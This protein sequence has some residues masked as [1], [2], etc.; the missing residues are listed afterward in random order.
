M[1]TLV[2]SCAVRALTLEPSAGRWLPSMVLTLVA[3]IAALLMPAS[4]AR[5]Q[6]FEE[7]AVVFNPLTKRSIDSAVLALNLDNDQ[8]D[9]AKDLYVGYRSAMKTAMREMESK[10]K[11][12]M[13]KARESGDWDAIRKGQMALAKEMFENVGKLEDRFNEDLKAMLS[14]EQAAKFPS[15]ERARRRENARL[16]QLMAGEAA[17]AIDILRAL[18]IDTASNEELKNLLNEYEMSF[19]RIVSDRLTALK[20]FVNKM[21]GG[22]VD[23]AGMMKLMADE[24]PK[25]YEKAKAGRELNKQTARRIVELLS[26]ADKKRFQDEVNR[27][28]HPKIYRTTSTGKKLDAAK[29]FEDLTDSQ[30]GTLE[31]LVASYARDTDAANKSWAEAV[32][33]AQ[34]E[35]G[36]NFE[37]RFQREDSA[38]A[39]RVNEA[40]DKR[41]EIEKQI[42]ERLEQLLNSDQNARLPA[43]RPDDEIEQHGD[44]TE[45]D[46]DKDAVKDWKD[47][48]E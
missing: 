10:G 28:S 3:A 13:E 33:D 41:R 44:Y 19:D 9:V 2:P 47:D 29:K 34:D 40:T 20:A 36:G 26:E 35:F 16:I 48:A 11:A 8:Q 15:Y 4:I 23:E 14:E 43:A 24:L 45:P 17:D 32:E 12:L 30:K 46:F 38:T 18:K 5:A 27:R 6:D 1:N 22:D 42:L 31:S 7:M 37:K 39:K 21:T 25:I